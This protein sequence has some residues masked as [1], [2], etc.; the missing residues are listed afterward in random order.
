MPRHADGLID[1]CLV[2]RPLKELHNG[3]PHLKVVDFL[4]FRS[5]FKWTPSANVGIGGGVP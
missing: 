3:N 5:H 2:V 1:Y 4:Y